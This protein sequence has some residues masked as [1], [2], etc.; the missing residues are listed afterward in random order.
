[1]RD[2]KNRS[3]L[4]TT[5]PIS[6]EFRV[7]NIFIFFIFLTTVESLLSVSWGSRR[8]MRSALLFLPPCPAAI[9]WELLHANY[10]GPDWSVLN[11]HAEASRALCWWW[12]CQPPT[13]TSYG[14]RLAERLRDWQPSPNLPPGWH[15]QSTARQCLQLKFNSC[16]NCKYHLHWI[17]GC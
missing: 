16:K 17:A 9:G 3:F 12:C 14:T 15:T 6:E 7:E 5:G 1:M 8:K 2:A 13:T 11:I 4:H 10:D